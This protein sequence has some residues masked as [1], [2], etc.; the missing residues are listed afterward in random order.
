MEKIEPL[1]DEILQLEAK[2]ELERKSVDDKTLAFTK[3]VNQNKLREFSDTSLV[4]ETLELSQDLDEAKVKYDSVVAN[5]EEKKNQLTAILNKTGCTQL[6][7]NSVD[8]INGSPSVVKYLFDVESGK[9][10]ITRGE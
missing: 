3:K 4:N 10:F 8:D 5:F 9:L 7:Y 2:T 6:L 1:L